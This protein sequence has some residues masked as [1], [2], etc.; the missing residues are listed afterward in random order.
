MRV[1]H[2]DSK[3]DKLGIW[4]HEAA[5]G[6]KAENFLGEARV[7]SVVHQGRSQLVIFRRERLKFDTVDSCSCL[8]ATSRRVALLE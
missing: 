7:A 6:S 3:I 4:I 5:F 2:L 8:V 1:Y